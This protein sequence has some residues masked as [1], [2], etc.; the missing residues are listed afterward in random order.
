MDY[1]TPSASRGKFAC[2]VVK[3]NLNEPLA[4]GIE[5]DGAWQRVEYDN[6][7]E[8]CFECG[9]V[10]HRH[11]S[12]PKNS[13]IITELGTADNEQKSITTSGE[14]PADPSAAN[15]YGP[16]L[17]VTCKGR[18]SDQ[19]ASSRKGK[20]QIRNADRIPD[21]PKFADSSGK[22]ISGEFHS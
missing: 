17:T 15:G 11:E 12:C 13:P 14:A 8:L 7:P 10:G 1:N 5:L 9:K 22:A 18:W 2:I 3:L 16:W 21:P 20:S 6:L 4:T 19:M